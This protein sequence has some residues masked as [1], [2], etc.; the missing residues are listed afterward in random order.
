MEIL[1]SVNGYELNK[2]D[3][4]AKGLFN[5]SHSEKNTLS[6]WFGGEI[7]DQLLIMSDSD[8]NDYAIKN[9]D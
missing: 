1:R 7:K 8:F 3:G 2:G 6:L 4:M 5:I 9:T